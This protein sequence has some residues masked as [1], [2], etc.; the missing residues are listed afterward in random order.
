MLLP[1][2]HYSYMHV[3]GMHLIYSNKK[4]DEIHFIPI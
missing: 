2:Y 1:E 3:A 4:Y